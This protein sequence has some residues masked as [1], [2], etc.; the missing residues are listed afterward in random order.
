MIK[1]K[2]EV[3]LLSFFVNVLR[4]YLTITNFK[5]LIYHNKSLETIYSKTIILYNKNEAP[6]KV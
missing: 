2:L 4:N 3:K 5:I 1:E 6:N